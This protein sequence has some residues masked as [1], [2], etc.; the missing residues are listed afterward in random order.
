MKTLG[1]FFKWLGGGLED[2]QGS[3]SSKR[4]ISYLMCWILYKIVCHSFEPGA[5]TDYTIL[6]WV[7]VLILVGLGVITTEIVMAFM[8]KE[9]PLLPGTQPHLQNSI[10]DTSK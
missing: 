5:T 2:Q 10:D 3:V 7:C 1:I 6:A 8:N 9:K 4:I